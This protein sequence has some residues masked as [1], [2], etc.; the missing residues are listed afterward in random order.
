VDEDIVDVAKK[1][2]PYLLDLMGEEAAE[3]D[4][5]IAGLLAEALDGHDVTDRLT[6]VLTQSRT[7]HAWAARVLENDR[8]LPPEISQ[9]RERGYQPLPGRGEA[10]DAEKF[11]CPSGDYVWYRMSVGDPIPAC[12]T[13]KSLLVAS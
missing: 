8:H 1:I 12:P 7:T 11:E 4:R 10:F 3:C 5:T 6:D 13:H 9:A 2:R